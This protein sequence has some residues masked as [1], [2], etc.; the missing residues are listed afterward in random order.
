MLLRIW[1]VDKLHKKVNIEEVV[2]NIAE[3]FGITDKL[4]YF[5]G[6]NMSNNSTTIGN[7][8][9]W[10]YESRSIRFNTEERRLGYWGHIMNI[11]VKGLLLF[12]LKVKKLKKEHLPEETVKSY[13]EVGEQLALSY[14][15]VKFVQ[16]NP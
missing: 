11:I 13:I 7:V 10:I 12:G 8:N 16:T 6:D 2:Y 14:N 15:I 5:M 9:S 3:D 1:K 4:S